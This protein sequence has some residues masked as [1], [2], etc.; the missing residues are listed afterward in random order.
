MIK[1]KH[2]HSHLPP[3]LFTSIFNGKKYPPFSKDWHN[4]LVF[5]DNLQILKSFYNVS[6][7]LV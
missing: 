4:L 2:T 3:V 5:G 6:K 1:Y 7:I